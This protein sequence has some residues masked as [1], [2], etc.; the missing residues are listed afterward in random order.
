MALP[1][2]SIASIVMLEHSN[3]KLECL[4]VP[5]AMLENIR[6]N[7]ELSVNTIALTAGQVRTKQVQDN[8]TNQTA[9]HV[10][11]GTMERGPE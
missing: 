9:F 8:K 3:Q 10:A 2:K 6:H 1:R 7:L 11:L 5:C 4:T